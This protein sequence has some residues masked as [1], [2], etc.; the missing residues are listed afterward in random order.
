MFVPK[1][2]LT[3]MHVLMVAP[4]I[5]PGPNM[6]EPH[7]PRVFY[8]AALDSDVPANQYWRAVPLESAV[9]DLSKFKGRDAPPTVPD[10]DEIQYLVDVRD[11][12]TDALPD[13]ESPGNP[14]PNLA[15]RLTLPPGIA[16]TPKPSEKW[17]LKG[18]PPHADK[19]LDWAAWHVVWTV[20]CIEGPTLPWELKKLSSDPVEPLTPL[21]PDGN[22]VIRLLISNSV[23][24][25]S[26]HEL[27]PAP[28]PKKGTPMPHFQSFRDLYK[29]RPSWPQLLFN[30]E[31]PTGPGGT[32]YTCLPSGG[33]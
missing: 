3:K 28:R 19:D 22:G 5:E 32:P 31:D 8:D 16:T 14:I 9:L 6:A 18:P 25:E 4:V 15:C 12:I 13:P 2:D 10:I 26:T 20:P 30:G 11:Y 33:K 7:Y 23:R 27:L 21:K 1:P 17:K 24:K 29:V